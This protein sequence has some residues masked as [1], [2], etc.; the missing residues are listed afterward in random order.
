[1]G[2]PVPNV[3]DYQCQ[4]GGSMISGYMNDGD[5]RKYLDQGLSFLARI[6]ARD[7]AERQRSLFGYSGYSGMSTEWGGVSGYSGAR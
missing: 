6:I 3:A 4:M 2:A 5:S 1:M 7:F